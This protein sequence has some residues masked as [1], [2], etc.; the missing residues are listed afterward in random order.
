MYVCVFVG[1][2]EGRLGPV[3]HKGPSRDLGRGH[4]RHRLDADHAKEEI[5]RGTLLGCLPSQARPC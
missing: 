2:L 4:R 3:S 5:A 1:W